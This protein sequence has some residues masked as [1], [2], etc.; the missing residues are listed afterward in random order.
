MNFAQKCYGLQLS[1]TLQFRG[2]EKLSD[3][4]IIQHEALILHLPKWIVL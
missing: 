2:E 4:A 1:N 3:Q